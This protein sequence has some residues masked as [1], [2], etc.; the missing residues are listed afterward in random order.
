MICESLFRR[1]AKPHKHTSSNHGFSNL[2]MCNSEHDVYCKLSMINRTQLTHKHCMQFTMWCSHNVLIT[3]NTFD[4]WLCIC[5]TENLRNTFMTPKADL[6]TT[7][8][9]QVIED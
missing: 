5:G 9:S 6:T 2:Q 8:L 1:S 4:P 7:Y 3:T